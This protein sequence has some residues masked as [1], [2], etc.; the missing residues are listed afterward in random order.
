[1]ERADGRPRGARDQPS[2]R[3]EGALCGRSLYPRDAP[4]RTRRRRPDTGPRG[5][6][7]RL[8]GRPRRAFRHPRPRVVK[9]EGPG[10]DIGPMA[11][12]VLGIGLIMAAIGLLAWAFPRIP[13]RYRR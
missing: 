11:N 5:Q 9:P 4:P 3:P 10:A 13:R 8:R 6:D 7:R 2:G 12:L 1:R